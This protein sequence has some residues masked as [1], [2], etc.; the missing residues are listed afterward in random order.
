MYDILIERRKEIYLQQN[1]INQT[2]KILN[3]HNENISKEF[4]KLQKQIANNSKNINDLFEIIDKEITNNYD[5]EQ[6]LK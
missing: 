1:Y 6:T 3:N 2:L 5:K 4:N